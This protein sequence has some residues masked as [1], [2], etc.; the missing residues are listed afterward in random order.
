[1]ELGNGRLA[2][3]DQPVCYTQHVMDGRGESLLVT[4]HCATVA[5][6]SAQMGCRTV[7]KS[8]NKTVCIIQLLLCICL[9]RVDLRPER[10]E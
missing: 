1:M 9:Y 10:N 5:T 3:T 2:T 8:A 7:D 4:K 6:C